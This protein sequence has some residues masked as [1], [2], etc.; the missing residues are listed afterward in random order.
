VGHEN[1]GEGDPAERLGRDPNHPTPRHPPNARNPGSSAQT[2]RQ[3]WRATGRTHGAKEGEADLQGARRK[4]GDRLAGGG[5]KG[6]QR[7]TGARLMSQFALREPKYRARPYLHSCVG[8]DYWRVRS[9]GHHSS[10]VSITVLSHVRST[11]V[12]RRSCQGS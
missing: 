5:S 8:V 7:L 6:E 10:P 12:S 2:G 11:H 9:C 4:R 1:S 3:S